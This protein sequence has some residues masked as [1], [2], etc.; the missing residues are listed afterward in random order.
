MCKQLEIPATLFFWVLSIEISF[1]PIMIHN[2]IDGNATTKKWEVTL[3]K[4]IISLLVG[5]SLNLV[6]KIIIQLIAISFHLRTYAD[7]IE[8]NK[9]Q[10]GSLTKLYEYSKEKIAMDDSD[11]EEGGRSGLA[12]GVRTP[13]Q[14][15]DKAQ[16]N[17]RDVFSKVGDVAGKV[18]GDFTGKEV[19]RSTH[20]RQVVLTLLSTTSGSQVLARRLY[21]TFVQEGAET[22]SAQDLKHAFESNEETDSAFTMVCRLQS[23]SVDRFRSVSAHV[24]SVLTMIQFDRDLN[25]DIS[26]SELE[27]VC[28][29]IGRER[30]SI[31]ASL[32]DLDSVV[33]KLDSILLFFVLIITLLILISLTSTSAAGV[34]TSAG[35]AVSFDNVG[36]LET[37]L[38]K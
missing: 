2:H 34:L 19:T 36:Q 35:S 5:A 16:K 29:E 11:F 31:T 25:G 24:R 37:L 27:S 28:V 30:K 7:R 15:L 12:S 21:R 14:Y 20:P 17:A 6:E 10:I 3:N 8:L 18:A 32:K 23:A 33:S 13:M 38:M 1:L 4:V 22:V 26:M 9:F